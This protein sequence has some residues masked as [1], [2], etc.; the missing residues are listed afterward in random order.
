MGIA[1]VV[2]A[3]VAAV[4]VGCSYLVPIR[5]AYWRRGQPVSVQSQMT[6]SKPN[7]YP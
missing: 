4:A 7:L 1:A 3:V 6:N 5:D 2:A